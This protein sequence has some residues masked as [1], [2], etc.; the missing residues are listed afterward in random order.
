MRYIAAHLNPDSKRAVERRTATIMPSYEHTVR[1][2]TAGLGT[3]QPIT[4][5][6]S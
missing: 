3:L 6:P 5:S 4:F 2:R 1:P